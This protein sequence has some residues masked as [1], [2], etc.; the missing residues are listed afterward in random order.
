MAILIVTYDL[1]GPSTQYAKLYEL[2]KG[3]D[4]WSHYLGSTWLV[5]TGKTPKELGEEI[6][7][8][9]QQE[10]NDSFLVARFTSDYWGLLPKDAW[11]WITT[12]ISK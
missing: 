1:K 7:P 12:H 8:L 5:A 10:K 2:L 9:V 4:S 11:T 3:Q 6:R